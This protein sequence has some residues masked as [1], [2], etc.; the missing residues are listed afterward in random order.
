VDALGLILRSELRRRWRSWLALALLIALVGGIVMAAAAAGRRTAS[1]FPTFVQT[2]GLDALIFAPNGAPLPQ[3]ARYPAVAS[4]TTVPI[5]YN[6]Q[7][8]CDC[9]RPIDNNNFNVMSVP[10]RATTRTTNLVAGTMPDPSSPDEVLA[11]FTLQRDNG[12]HVGTVMRMRMYAASQLEAINNSTGPGPR[13]RGPF[14]SLRVVGIEAAAYEFQAGTT[15][16]YDVYTTPAF[17]RLVL[18]KTPIGFSYLVNLRHGVADVDA[19]KTYVKALPGGPNFIDESTPEVLVAS[20]IHPQAVGWWLLA[21]LAALAGAA[22]VGQAISRTRRVES[23]EYPTL[24]A[25]GLGRRGLLALGMASTLLVGLAGAVGAVALAYALSPLAPV[26]IARLAEPSSGLRFDGLVLLVGGAATVVVVLALGVWPSLR[27]ARGMPDDAR[28]SRS[29]AVAGLLGAAGA[30]PT[31]V[32]GVRNALERGRGVATSP[33]ATALLGAVLAVTALCGT[34]VFGSSL[35]H[36]DA[37]PS[38]FGDSYQ[39]IIY[40]TPGNGPGGFIGGQSLVK[41]L[42]RHRGIDQITLVTGAPISINGVSIQAATYRSVR[43]SALVEPVTGRLPVHDGEIALGSSTIRRIGASVG[44]VVRVRFKS[45]SGRAPSA[46][47]R[48]VGTVVLPTG[49][50][51]GE[52]GLGTGAVLPLAGYEHAACPPGKAGVM[53]VHAIQNNLAVMASAAPGSAGHA[54]ITRLVAANPFSSGTP[55]TPTSLVNFGEAVN[56][57]LILGVVLAVFGAA[58][59]AHLLIVSVGR[60][61]REMGLLKALGFVSRQVGA[62]VYWQATTITVVGVLVGVPVGLALGR[63][64]W[65]AFALNIGVVPDPVINAGLIAGLVAAV[66]LGAFL[67]A[68]GPAFAAA[69]AR[70]ARLLRSE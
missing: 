57:P 11:S 43:G 62:T 64:I 36:L 40:G 9:T 30:P 52:V 15:A 49:V 56:F 67:L 5:A 21:A 68:V 66:L 46:S 53:C 58:T 25:L 60:R 14:V 61:R 55:I 3:L 18:P 13:P 24:K 33:V 54:A 10:S 8:R 38:L 17:A 26:G 16:L 63:V 70:P 1:A 31:M 19:F 69:R 2:H 42:E 48:V 23:D 7:P 12:V 35:A 34:A 4:I 44:G 20:S 29:S 65:R 50:G 51:D 28:L 47:L 45:P 32:V 27:A 59:L 39:V 22:V 6:G 41:E 37:T